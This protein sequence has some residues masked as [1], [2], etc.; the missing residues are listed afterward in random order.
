M[1]KERVKNHIRKVE[2]RTKNKKSHQLPR[3]VKY[4]KISEIGKKQH[5]KQTSKV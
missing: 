4:A 2:Q 3:A 1:D 5:S